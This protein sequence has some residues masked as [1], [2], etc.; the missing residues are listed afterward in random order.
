MALGLEDGWRIPPAA[1]K[2]YSSRSVHKVVP[3][4]HVPISAR[5]PSGNHDAVIRMNYRI[6]SVKPIPLQTI[7][8]ILFNELV[9]PNHTLSSEHWMRLCFNFT[10][11]RIFIVAQLDLK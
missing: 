4:L 9:K 11:L 6:G 3:A 5:S 8:T 7:S 1:F 10:S 2:V